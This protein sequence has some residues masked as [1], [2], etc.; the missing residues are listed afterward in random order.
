MAQFEH[1]SIRW[2]DAMWKDPQTG[3]HKLGDSY[4]SESGS[5][6]VN[7]QAS[8]SNP[9]GYISVTHRP[10]NSKHEGDF[11]LIDLSIAQ[12]KALRD[13]LNEFIAEAE[14]AEVKA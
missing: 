1:K 11:T 5:G 3:K 7:R 4:H 9:F 10:M 2:A 13:A 6:F 12:G 14:S 8:T